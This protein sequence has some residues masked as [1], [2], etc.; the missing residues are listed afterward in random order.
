MITARIVPSRPCLTDDDKAKL[1]AIVKAVAPP[2]PLLQPPPP[3]PK[4]P[5]QPPAR[6]K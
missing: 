6:K 1:R 3:P 4:Q 2:V 5:A